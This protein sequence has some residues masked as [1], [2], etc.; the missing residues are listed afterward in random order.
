MQSY[1]IWIVL[2]QDRSKGVAEFSLSDMQNGTITRVGSL[3][4]QLG[5]SADLGIL[6]PSISSHVLSSPTATSVSSSHPKYTASALVLGSAVGVDPKAL[7]IFCKSLRAVNPIVEIVIFVE[8]PTSPL[9]VE[10]AFDAFVNLVQVY[11]NNECTLSSQIFM[12]S[13]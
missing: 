2:G 4:E 10:I 12:G 7:T 5:I 11:C 1:V 3:R 9:I 13:L 6:S 8:K